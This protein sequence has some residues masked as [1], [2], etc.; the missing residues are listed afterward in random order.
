[1][2]LRLPRTLSSINTHS[3]HRYNLYLILHTISFNGR[4]YSITTTIFP[5]NTLFPCNDLLDACYSI[6]LNWYAIYMHAVLSSRGPRHIVENK[7]VDMGAMHAHSVD[8][9]KTSTTN[10][11]L[12]ARGYPK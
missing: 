3:I 4:K 1:M 5:Y 2:I 10:G 6:G 7:Y 9:A 11:A 12:Y 8:H